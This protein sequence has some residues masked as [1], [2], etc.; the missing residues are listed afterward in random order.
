[1]GCPTPGSEW[2]AI[3]ESGWRSERN[4]SQTGCLGVDLRSSSRRRLDVVVHAEEIR[5]IVL[6]L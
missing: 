4:W 1:M 6:V 3:L 2:E 5:G